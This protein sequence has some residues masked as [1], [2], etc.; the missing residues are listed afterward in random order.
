MRPP[1]AVNGLWLVDR[2]E[3]IDGIEQFESF[4][5]TDSAGVLKKIGMLRFRVAVSLHTVV[6]SP[7]R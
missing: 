5:S 1:R 7:S 4:D 3:G 2:I 6:C